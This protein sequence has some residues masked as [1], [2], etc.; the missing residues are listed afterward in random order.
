MELKRLNRFR[1]EYIDYRPLLKIV[2]DSSEALNR[3]ILHPI[4]D[5][6]FFTVYRTNLEID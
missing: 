1:E 4:P 6:P 3:Y 5:K 2:Y